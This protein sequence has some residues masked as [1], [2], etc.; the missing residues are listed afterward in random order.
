LITPRRI[1]ISFLLAACLVGLGYGL[2]LNRSPATP[3]IYN[4]PA[5]R[6]LTPQPG[7]AVPRQSRIG[8]TLATAFTLGSTNAFGMT[9]QQQGIPQD[10]MEIIAGLKQFWYTPGSG[11]QITALAPGR[12]CVQLIIRR[13]ADQADPGRPFSWC[14]FS[15]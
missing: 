12:N 9:I 5:I 10:Q 13:E 14:F 2:S 8:V 11:K 4:D 1:V 7:T 15:Q 6:S 3:V